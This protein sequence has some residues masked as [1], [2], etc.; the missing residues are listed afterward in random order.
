MLYGA[1]SKESAGLI[2]DK[3]WS[4]FPKHGGICWY[5]VCA[6]QQSTQRALLTRA[7]LLLMM[8][9]GFRL[10]RL[11]IMLRQKMSPTRSVHS[12]DSIWYVRSTQQH[13]LEGCQTGRLL[14]Q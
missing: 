3:N 6:I 11:P 7:V 10:R 9:A 8:K 12:T 4:P 1:K 5:S 13:K 2:V 14:F